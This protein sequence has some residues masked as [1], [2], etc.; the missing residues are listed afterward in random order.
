MNKEIKPLVGF[1]D[2]KFGM[3]MDEVRSK[4][5]EPEAIDNDM[6]YTDDEGETDDLTTVFYYDSQ[7]LSLSFDKAEGYRLTEMSFEDDQFALGELHIG[8]SKE[9]AFSAALEAGLGECEEDFLDDEAEAEGLES[10]TYEEKNVSLWF[11]DD[12][13]DTIQIGPDFEDDDTIKWPQ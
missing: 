1:G 13:L 5:G 3:S 10:F 8:M 6:N 11:A 4:L 2:I 7:G 12:L 9:E